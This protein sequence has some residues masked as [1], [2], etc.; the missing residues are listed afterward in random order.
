MRVLHTQAVEQYPRGDPKDQKIQRGSLPRLHPGY[1]ESS[2]DRLG[3]AVPFVSF[4][5]RDSS[6]QQGCSIFNPLPM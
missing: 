5:G 2:S 3:P 4:P 6:K 1:P